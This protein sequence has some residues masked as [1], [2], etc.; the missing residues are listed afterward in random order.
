[1]SLDELDGAVRQVRPTEGGGRGPRG[2]LGGARPAGRRRSRQAIA[3]WLKKHPKSFR[4]R[5]RLAARL[6]AERKW[7]EAKAVLLEREGTLPGICRAGERLRAAGR[8]STNKRS[9][10]AAEHEVWRNWRRATATPRRPTCGCMELDEAAGDWPAVA[11]NAHRLLA[12]NPLIPAPHRQL[13]RAAEHLGDATRRSPPTGPSP[14][15]TTPTRPRC[16]TAWRSCSSQAGKTDEARREVLKSLEEAPRFLDR[17]SLL[18][19]LVEPT[20][21]T[22]GRPAATPGPEEA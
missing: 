7:P 11:R 19:E 3:T 5:R 16:I 21:T 6:V 2:N 4:G 22:P 15:S 13:A 1:M 10:P 17:P 9:D 18:L 14:C 8:A 12:V 20:G